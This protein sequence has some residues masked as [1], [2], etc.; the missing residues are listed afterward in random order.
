M[1]DIISTP[2]TQGVTLTVNPTTITGSGSITA[3]TGNAVTGLDTAWTVANE[4]SVTASAAGANGIDLADGGSIGNSGQISGYQNGVDVVTGVATVTNTGTIDSSPTKVVSGSPA[5][6]YDGIYLGGGGTVTN[7]GTGSIFGS[8]SGIDIAGGTGTVSNTGSI[9]TTT[10]QGNGVA[11]EAGGTVTNGAGGILYGDFSGISVY[12]AAGYVT[13]SGVIAAIGLNGAGIYFAAGG[14]ITNTASGSI[15]GSYYGIYL[16]GGAATVTNAG[17]IYGT[18]TGIGFE[19]GLVTNLSG[20][21]ILSSAVGVAMGGGTLVNAG[22]IE[23]TLS[24]GTAV[25]FASG[26]SEVLVVEAG[27][28]FVGAVTGGGAGSVL[29]LGAVPSGTTSTISGIGGQI[30]GFDTITFNTGNDW[31]AAGTLSAFNGDTITGFALGDTI[32]LDGVTGLTS[33]FNAQTGVLT[34]NDGGTSDSLTFGGTL[35]GDLEVQDSGGGDSTITLVPCFVAGTRIATPRG[36]VP[37]EELTPGDEVLTVL[38]EVLPIIWAGSREIDCDTYPKPDRVRPIR[39]QAHAF[40]EGAPHRD[41]LVSPD[42]AVLAQGVLIPA[43]QLVNGATIR[44]LDWSSVTYHHIE[45]SRHAVIVSE[46]LPTESY[47]DIGDRATFA[48][49]H[50]AGEQPETAR[51][52]AQMIRDALACAPIRIVGPEVEQVRDRLWLRAGLAPALVGSHAA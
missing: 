17:Y 39:I 50:G 24:N 28:D 48:E 52:E 19:D 42:H 15:N 7:S 33:T 14:T 12:G 32:V 26:A 47:L 27:A 25:S 1:S 30:T 22:T 35:D 23:A 40:A 37:V 13:N 46:G 8:I 34:L 31:I 41:L 29:E 2:I 16:A 38:G 20:A 10:L 3:S 6:I 45:L 49:G 43:K 11:L 21:V 18:D 44:Q 4:G 9:Q 51:P 36:E 5:Y